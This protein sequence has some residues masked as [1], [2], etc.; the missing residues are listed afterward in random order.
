[1]LSFLKEKVQENISDKL[2][3]DVITENA[4]TNDDMDEWIIFGEA[5]EETPVEDPIPEEE[6]KDLGDAD[7]EAPEDAGN[8][9]IE[10]EEP[11]TD[12]GN[13]EITDSEIEAIPTGNPEPDAG[14]DLGNA[15]LNTVEL[16]LGSNSL[17]DVVPIAPRG[18][19]T[20]VIGD[21][22]SRID[23]NPGGNEVDL[24]DTPIDAPAPVKED[25]G[26]AYIDGPGDMSDISMEEMTGGDI[27]DTPIDE[28]NEFDYSINDSSFYEMF[29][30]K[31]VKDKEGDDS[32]KVIADAIKDCDNNVNIDDLFTSEEE[33]KKWEKKRKKNNK[34]FNEAISFGDGDGSNEGNGENA[35]G[36][37]APTDTPP[38]IEGGDSGT[39]AENDIT[40]AVR[41][42]VSEADG[43]A[44]P[45]G[46]S[47]SMGSGS[48][49]LSSEE[50]MKKLV[51]ITKN[52]EDIKMDLVKNA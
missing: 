19:S 23:N 27:G 2:S 8:V 5:G 7:I 44:D 46:D 17:T 11:E 35:E 24:G 47:M 1:M 20:N 15:P 13:D 49:N 51:G 40:S 37:D 34:N 9:P 36:G 3:T 26:S 29:G 33:R 52:I 18:A 43:S 45:A 42:K 39:S 6:T 38:D 30:K 21:M 12:I 16:D 31:K 10:P 50:L 22:N 14:E 32:M 4:T 48:S 41:D 25:I 28:S